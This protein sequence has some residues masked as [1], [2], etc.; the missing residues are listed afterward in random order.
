MRD[1]IKDVWRYLRRRD[2][3]SACCLMIGLGNALSLNDVKQMADYFEAL[4][5]YLVREQERTNEH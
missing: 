2:S 4:H 1:F 3:E 5:D